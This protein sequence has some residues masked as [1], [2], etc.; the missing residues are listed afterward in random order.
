MSCSITYGTTGGGNKEDVSANSML[1]LAAAVL[2]AN[3]SQK[4]QQVEM[5]SVRNTMVVKESVITKHPEM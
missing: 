1:S 3:L 4:W 2:V 5:Y